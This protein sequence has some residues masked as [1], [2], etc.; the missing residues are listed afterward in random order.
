M[1]M[2]VAGGILGNTKSPDVFVVVVRL[3]PIALDSAVTFAFGTTAPDGSV[4]LPKMVPEV[5]WATA[6]LESNATIR[7]INKEAAARLPLGDM[8]LSLGWS[9]RIL[10]VLRRIMIFISLNYGGLKLREWVRSA[11]TLEWIGIPLFESS[12]ISGYVA[13][14]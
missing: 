12:S 5:T 8:G 2:Y 14:R 1:R 4:I 6:P 7:R 13:S 10:A 11:N 9:L 3:T